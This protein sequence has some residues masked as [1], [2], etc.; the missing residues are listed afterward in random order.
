MAFEGNYRNAEDETASRL[1]GKEGGVGVGGRRVALDA[2]NA[3]GRAAE[4]VVHLLSTAEVGVSCVCRPQRDD[5]DEVDDEGVRERRVVGALEAAEGRVADDSDG[6]QEACRVDVHT[7]ERVDR[8]G[9]AEDQHSGDDE[10]REHAE[11]QESEV[12]SCA[13]PDLDYLEHGVNRGALALDLDGD[14][15]EENDLDS[16]TSGIPEGPRHAELVRNVG[17]L[18]ERRL[19][20]ACPGQYR[21]M[22]PGAQSQARQHK[23]LGLVEARW[24]RDSPP[25][26]TSTQRRPR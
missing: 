6:D 24:P 26:S 9:A 22:S 4:V 21:H 1:E 25:R 12:C 3:V 19:R 11:P 20:I 8:G 18:E 7:R 15:G 23:Q 16:G 13:P 2:A 14:D 10:R 17:G 5:E